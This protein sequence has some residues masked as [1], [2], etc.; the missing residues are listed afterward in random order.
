M[1]VQESVYDAVV[2]KLKYRMVGMN[3][4]RVSDECEMGRMDAAVHVAEQQGAMVSHW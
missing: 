3:C 1:C 4:V 2:E